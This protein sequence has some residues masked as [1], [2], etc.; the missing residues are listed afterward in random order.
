MFATQ[1]K[2]CILF[3]SS[4]AIFSTCRSLTIPNNLCGFMCW[5]IGVWLLTFGRIYVAHATCWTVLSCSLEFKV[6]FFCAFFT[7]IYSILFVMVSNWLRCFLWYFL[8]FAICCWS[9]KSS[10][11]ARRSADLVVCASCT[12]A[13]LSVVKW[14]MRKVWISCSD[15]IFCFTFRRKNGH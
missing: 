2:S 7:F 1:S 4:T 12:I 6:S 8:Y 3:R 5:C 9:S 13:H 14:C 10:T 11:L 15:S